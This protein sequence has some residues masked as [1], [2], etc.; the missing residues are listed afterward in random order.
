MLILGP[1][2]DHCK[3]LADNCQI[4][5]KKRHTDHGPFS[6]GHNVVACTG[7][8]EPRK[9][10]KL[11]KQQVKSGSLFQFAWLSM[12]LKVVFFFKHL[13]LVLVFNI[14]LIF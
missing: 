8:T 4:A 11:V 1:R 2:Y 7:L 6:S 10:L 3:E 13:S 14:L 12:T 5:F 9:H